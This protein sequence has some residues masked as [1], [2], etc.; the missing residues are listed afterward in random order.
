MLSLYQ[1]KLL[2]KDQFYILYSEEKNASIHFPVTGHWILLSI[3]QKTLIIKKQKLF[4]E[5]KSIVKEE[6]VIYKYDSLF[7]K[8]KLQAIFNWTST[9]FIRKYFDAGVESFHGKILKVAAMPYF[10]YTG[11]QNYNSNGKIWYYGSEVSILRVIAEHLQFKIDIYP[12]LDGKWGAEDPETGKWYRMIFEVMSGKVDIAMG[13]ITSTYSRSFVEDFVTRLRQD[14]LTFVTPQAKEIPK[15]VVLKIPFEFS[16]WIGIGLTLVA[17]ILVLI[18]IS[19]I[20]SQIGIENKYYQDMTNI[21]FIIISLIFHTPL[22]ENSYRNPMRI[23]IATLWVFTIVI[24]IG[25]RAMLTSLLTIPMFYEPITY[26]HELA[27]SDLTPTMYDYGGS[28]TEM[29]KTSTDP[30]YEAIWKIME[31]IASLF[32]SMAKIHR[33]GEY[34]LMDSYGSLEI[35]VITH[36]TNP[37]N[38]L[39]SIHLMTNCFGH[40]SVAWPIKYDFPYKRA[41]NEAVTRLKETGLV[42]KYHQNLIDEVVMYHITSHVFHELISVSEIDIFDM[43]PLH[44]CS[45]SSYISSSRLDL[46]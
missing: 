32:E 18:L 13:G 45:K 7:P 5:S 9:H 22:N 40:F 24:T 33:G 35:L 8:T 1:R 28:W 43:I 37:I 36:Y 12:P 21:P 2:K 25:Y 10:P 38:Q 44:W 15:W 4:Y 20:D 42:D 46:T 3:V 27:I 30:D 17:S 6:L 26:I 14:C 23:F 11:I 16:V 34:A 31:F 39:S 41:L 29:L 19:Q